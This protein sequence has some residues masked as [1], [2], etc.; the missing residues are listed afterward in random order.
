MLK[1]EKIIVRIVFTKQCCEVGPFFGRVR[2]LTPDQAPAPDGKVSFVKKFSIFLRLRTSL[3][4]GHLF[5]LDLSNILEEKM[6][7]NSFASGL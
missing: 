3:D 6:F 2:A 1:N 5:S 7:K 4:T